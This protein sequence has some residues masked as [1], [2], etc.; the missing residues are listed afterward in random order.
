[1]GLMG[2]ACRCTESAMLCPEEKRVYYVCAEGA[3]RRRESAQTRCAC[4]CV[5]PLGD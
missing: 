3:T 5:L 4:G 2:R 1:L